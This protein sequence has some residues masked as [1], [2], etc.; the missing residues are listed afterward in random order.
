MV[1]S[2]VPIS[3][4]KE[5]KNNLKKAWQLNPCALTKPPHNQLPY[6]LKL[7]LVSYECWIS[8]SGLSIARYNNK[9]HSIAL[10]V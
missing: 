1:F 8:I 2:I 4:E 7:W 9:M 3:K 10:H 6:C 5:N